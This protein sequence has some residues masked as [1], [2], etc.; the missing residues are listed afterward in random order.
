MRK[1]HT[2]NQLTAGLFTTTDFKTKIKDFFTM[3]DRIRFVLRHGYYP[4]ALYNAD[5]YLGDMLEEIL[6]W[7]IDFGIA[8]PWEFETREEWEAVL[9]KMRKLNLEIRED[10]CDYID[11]VGTFFNPE[12]SA[13]FYKEREEKQTELFN[14]LNKY[15]RCLWD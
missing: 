7:H 5:I 6:Q 8:C 15:I 10:Y 12:E 2:E 9:K 13:K 4:Q 14:M 11:R 1:E 3:L